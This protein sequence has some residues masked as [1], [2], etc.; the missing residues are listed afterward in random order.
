[1]IL[2]VTSR[3][4]YLSPEETKKLR[5]SQHG[6]SCFNE[7]TISSLSDTILLWSS[8]GTVLAFNSLFCAECVLGDIFEFRSI[9]R[10]NCFHSGTG[11]IFYE[12]D[13][14]FDQ[15]CS[16]AFMTKEINPCVTRVVID[17]HKTVRLLANT[18]NIHWTKE[19]HV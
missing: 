18:E 9:V 1:M 8:W 12:S 4:N 3:V 7:S 10:S 14:L 6:S 19:I 13:K 11:L 17:N 16:L 15:S 2:D 5:V